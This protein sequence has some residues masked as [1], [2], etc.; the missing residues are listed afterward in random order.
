LYY[1]LLADAVEPMEMA[2]IGATGVIEA[3]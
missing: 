1:S 2:L 3:R